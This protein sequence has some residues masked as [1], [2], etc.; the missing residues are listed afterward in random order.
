[1]IDLE[2]AKYI[3]ESSRDALTSTKARRMDESS[4][5]HSRMNDLQRKMR[6]L[7]NE[8]INARAEIVFLEWL[9]KHGVELILLASEEPE[10]RR[11]PLDRKPNDE[12]PEKAAEP[13]LTPF[14]GESWR[15]WSRRARRKAD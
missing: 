6:E 4:N 9:E 5:L 12:L 11:L 1:M 15:V 3:F 2:L 14:R 8:W 13:E 7:M 10:F